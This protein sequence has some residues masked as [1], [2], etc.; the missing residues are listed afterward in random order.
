MRSWLPLA[1][2]LSSCTFRV[3]GV[4]LTDLS[5]NAND[6]SG[7]HVDDLASSDGLVGGDGMSGD[8]MSSDALV[9]A[10]PTDFTPASDLQCVGG[11]FGNTLR[12]CSVS[13]ATDQSCALGCSTSGSAH[14]L[15]FVPSGGAVT[16]G[17]LTVGGLSNVIISANVVLDSDTGAISGGIRNATASGVIDHGIEYRSSGRTGIFIFNQLTVAMGFTVSLRGSKAVALVSESDIHLDGVLDGTQPCTSPV[18]SPG[19]GGEFGG[20]AGQSSAGAG[21]GGAGQGA[22]NQASGGGGG[23]YGA[24]GGAGGSSQTGTGAAAVSGGNMVALDLSKLQGGFGG[25]GAQSAGGGGGAAIQL[26]AGG[27]IIVTNGTNGGINAGGCGARAYTTGSGNGGGGGGSGGLILLEAQSINVS[28]TLAA[29]GGGGAAGD[30]SGGAGQSGK[31]GTA[32]ASGGVNSNASQTDAG[33]GGA[34]GTKNSGAVDGTGGTGI[35]NGGGGGGGVGYIQLNVF[36]SQFT[37]AAG[38]YS[39]TQ[40]IGAITLQ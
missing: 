28:G 11:C 33:G 39:P 38:T 5:A 24:V 30:T 27:S 26:V 18:P 3:T 36:N 9:D 13:G 2:L 32:V 34:G 14:C 10:T 8:A 40:T 22:H 35:N 31:L 1:V 16:S 37:D 15:Q 25:G 20:A 21:H 4:D 6:L 17:D 12:T 29:N 19:P 7:G 23:G